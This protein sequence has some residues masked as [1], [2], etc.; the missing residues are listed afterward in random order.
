MGNGV[1]GFRLWVLFA[2]RRS[3]WRIKLSK[4]G[5]IAVFYLTPW[6]RRAF[7]RVYDRYEVK[8]SGVMTFE[9]VYDKIEILKFFDWK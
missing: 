1:I 6:H 2:L 8:K 5:Y 9:E 7:F 3:K 4:G